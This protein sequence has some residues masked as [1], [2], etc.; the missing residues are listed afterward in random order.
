MKNHYLCAKRSLLAVVLAFISFAFIPPN[1]LVHIFL[2]GDST[3]ADKLTSAYPETGWGTRMRD[4]FDTTVSIV[5]KAKNGR[6]TKTFKAEGIWQQITDSLQQGDYVIIQFGHNDEVPTK[7]SYTPEKEFKNNL[8][9]MVSE[10]RKKKA[11]P[12]LISP[13]ARRKFDST[14][15]VVD[16][17]IKYAA[18]VKKVAADKK[19][20]FIDLNMESM[21][22]IQKF[23]REDSKFLF[24]HLQPGQNPNYPD[25][26]IDD[27]HFNELGARK[28][29]ELVLAELRKL[30]PDLNKRIVTSTWGAQ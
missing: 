29:G 21:A 9:L 6:S 24:N 27:T 23:G 26:K 3:M 17:H 25:G 18:M 2:A 28:M 10:V 1:R 22:L 11:T 8:Q 4:F 5:N 13:V 30:V 16:T 19:V 7:A 12:I 15:H 14:G 20:L